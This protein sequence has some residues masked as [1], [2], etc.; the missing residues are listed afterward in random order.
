MYHACHTVG[1]NVA[2]LCPSPRDFREAMLKNGEHTP[3]VPASWDAGFV[4]R[5]Q[6]QPSKVIKT[7]SKKQKMKDEYGRNCMY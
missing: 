6:G 4:L 5:V 7:P 3:A 1:K 2:A